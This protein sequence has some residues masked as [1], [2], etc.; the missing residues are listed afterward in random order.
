MKIKTSH[1][2]AMELAAGAALIALALRKKKDRKTKT[3]MP[4][5]VRKLIDT[6]GVATKEEVDALAQAL[7]DSAQRVGS[8]VAEESKLLAKIAAIYAIDAIMQSANT[9]GQQKT[10]KKKTTPKNSKPKKAKVRKKENKG[11]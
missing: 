10:G 1:I 6:V 2:K 5:E 7:K 9:A 4:P 11:K 3:S 8:V